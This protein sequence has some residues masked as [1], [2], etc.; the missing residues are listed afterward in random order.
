MVDQH[1]LKCMIR[2]AQ[3]PT[4]LMAGTMPLN[5]NTFVSVGIEY[6]FRKMW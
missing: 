4:I 2:K 1:I 6:D 5:L 3:V